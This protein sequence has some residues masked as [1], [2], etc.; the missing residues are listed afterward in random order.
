MKNRKGFTLI[1]V[2]VTLTI[3]SIIIT[4]IIGLYINSQ[5]TKQRV[6]AMTAAQQAGRSAIDFII[7]DLRA[8]GYNI[9]IDESGA[10]APQ[11]RI[12]YAGPYEVIINANLNP[13]SD[14]PDN[15]QTPQAYDPG[16]DPK[17]VHYN[18]GLKYSTG[19]ETIVYTL[20]YNNDGTVNSADRN[21]FEARMTS[22]PNDYALVKRVYGYDPTLRNN[23][24]V[25]QIV[26]VIAGPDVFPSQTTG[27]PIF[28][29]WYDHDAD[30]STPLKL[31]G[32]SDN[33]SLI[34]QAEANAMTFISGIDLLDKIERI[35]VGI[36]GVSPRS[37]GGDYPESY[38]QTDVSVTRNAS[39]TVYTVTGH[40]Y[41]D[42]NKDG[43]F[44]TGEP[45][46]EN[47]N[48][49][50]ST[51][52]TSVTD[53]SGIWSFALIPGPYVISVTPKVKYKPSTNTSMEISI[54][55][56]SLSYVNDSFFGMESIPTAT[57]NALA[58][59]DDVGDMNW[60]AEDELIEGI[61]ISTYNNSAYTFPNAAFP[62]N[63]EVAELIVNADDTIY[64][65]VTSV[66]S[67]TGSGIDSVLDPFASNLDYYLGTVTP[68]MF[69]AYIP[70]NE[71]MNVGFAMTKATGIKCTVDILY[72]TAGEVLYK[73]DLN[74]YIDVY[75]NGIDDNIT[76][77]LYYISYDN[78]ENWNYLT[79]FLNPPI[80]GTDSTFSL[81]FDV[82]DTS[83]DLCR[84]MVE[85]KDEG[86]WT[87]YDI[88]ESFSIISSEGFVLFYFGGNYIDETDDDTLYYHNIATTHTMRYLETTPYPYWGQSGYEME[89]WADGFYGR[90]PFK[91]QDG[92][93]AEWI[94]RSTSP[95]AD[96]LY[97]SL[98]IFN[99]GA[100]TNAVDSDIYFDV[101]VCKRDSTGLP[102]SE[103]T[104]FKTWGFT[105][106]TDIGAV[107][108][109]KAVFD[110]SSE[111]KTMIV[112]VP[113]KFDVDYTDRLYIKLFWTGMYD[114][115]D[116]NNGGQGIT[117]DQ[118]LFLYG[119]TEESSMH[120][121][122]KY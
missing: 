103:D 64:V 48:V 52:E 41:N 55:D 8:T 90:M 15:P 89:N 114:S 5:K 87:S 13:I 54:K 119:G 18:P 102:S 39:A 70:E 31:W 2:M 34:S 122:N 101:L 121:P 4:G 40:V 98:W 86:G 118:I 11:R 112:K 81:T 29:Y 22:N 107:V 36:T 62:N 60:D 38:V 3:F 42:S 59:I 7:K 35:T 115:S 77:L 66:D 108:L 68:S 83:S 96:T 12:A 113:V 47:F 23:G 51:G 6:D 37:I 109:Q 20:D 82:P 14:T 104:L 28:L 16:Y 21:S 49:R 91:N 65:W 78:G 100:Y 24:G 69:M 117:I 9:D 80:D 26:S 19:A 32:D 97:D 58:F 75:A 116:N 25:N 92:T 63:A 44:S 85:A 56:S 111:L 33:D 1:E 99:L 88:S 84:I 57:V 73:S 17:P 95:H 105:Y 50:L 67:Y 46:L 120:I 43:L 10:V 53:A 72:P 93:D 45:G 30:I 106:Y 61:Q 27:T 94:T 71:V 110:S 74:S 76:H 79:E